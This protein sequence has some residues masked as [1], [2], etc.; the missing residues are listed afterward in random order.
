VSRFQEKEKRGIVV[1]KVKNLS[2]IFGALMQQS[3]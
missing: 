3:H 2:L 1:K